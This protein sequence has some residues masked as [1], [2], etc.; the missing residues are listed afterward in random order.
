MRYFV[1]LA[2][3]SCMIAFCNAATK[4]ILWNQRGESSTYRTNDIECHTV[5][6]KFNGQNNQASANGSPMY[7]FSDSSCR[8]A[9]FL[10]PVGLGDRFDVASPIK[11]Y[12]AANYPRSTQ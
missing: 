2:V 10:D 12:R 1:V 9:V 8:V 6:S 4:V 7:Y 11:A 5:S 3:I